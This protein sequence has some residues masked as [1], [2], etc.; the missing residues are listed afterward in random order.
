MLQTHFL[1]LQQ[2][3]AANPLSLLLNIFSTADA[4][5]GA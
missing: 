3:R 1:S 4:T 5:V 2:C